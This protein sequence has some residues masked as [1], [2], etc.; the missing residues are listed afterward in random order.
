MT[1]SLK[2]P[3]QSPGAKEA[4]GELRGLE[5]QL[6]KTG[7]AGE[8]FGAKLQHAGD[9]LRAAR[10]IA[11][12]FASTVAGA[13]QTLID[14][15]VANEQQRRALE[16]LGSAYTA[17][18]AATRGAVTA[19]QALKTQQ[20]L[21]Q[22]GLRVSDQALA[23][24]TRTAREFARRTGGDTTQALEQLTE[25]LRNGDAGGLRR[26]GISVT[27]TGNRVRDFHR[28]LDQMS[29]GMRGATPSAVSL[30]EQ[31]QLMGQ[32]W[33][34]FKNSVTSNIA[35]LL[36][37]KEVFRGLTDLMR[38]VRE[39]GL[40]DGF[41]GYVR[42]RTQ[43]PYQEISEQ[44]L[45]AMREPGRFARAERERQARAT[46]FTQ[47]QQ[48]FITRARAGGVSARQLR[49]LET[50][51][52]GRQYSDQ[53]RESIAN[54][55]GRV[56]GRSVDAVA[57]QEGLNFVRRQQA[58]LDPTVE[59]RRE[60]EQ[61]QAEERA[62][63]AAMMQRRLAGQA[64][65]M[66]PSDAA[67]VREMG[68]Q[69]GQLIRQ[70]Q[71]AQLAIAQI[72]MRA[73]EGALH[74]LGRNIREFEQRLVTAQNRV[75]RHRGETEDAFLQRRIAVVQR[76]LQVVEEN[77]RAKREAI[78]ETTAAIKAQIEAD[79]R[80]KATAAN[81]QE[82]TRR[83]RRG[84]GFQLI[85]GLGQRATTAGLVQDAEGA[86]GLRGFNPGGAAR[87]TERGALLGRV[88]SLTEQAANTQDESTAEQLQA[89]AAAIAEVVGRYD[90]LRRS[91]QA[92][93]DTGLQF[94]QAFSQ[95]TELVSTSAQ[96][97]A[98]VASEAF[99]TFKGALK[100]HI[101]AVIAGKE[102]IG[103]ALRAITIATL[104]NLAERAGYEAIWETGK[105]IGKVA[106]G[107]YAG[108]GT[109]FA[110]AA[111]FTGL[112]VAGGFVANSLANGAGATA[113]GAASRGYVSQP[114]SATP[115]NSNAGGNTAV[116][117]INFNG[118][119]IGADQPERLNRF[120]SDH[121]NQALASGAIRRVA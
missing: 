20:D 88:Q 31:V 40:F 6:K 39:E 22:S 16:Q 62:E 111:A 70:A 28:A 71:R 96:T 65:G 82:I 106:L 42:E 86:L 90:E 104:S 78:D 93:N 112:A 33:D 46:A 121:V 50:L 89:Q 69:V 59:A 63:S 87:D 47:A 8:S 91:Q 29:A 37:L 56:G 97:M 12:A 105:G 38:H 61:R 2:V 95:H 48:Q 81:D 66:A 32:E 1:D 51:M 109:H 45:A 5:G 15:A 73:G 18:T 10:E 113:T 25:A 77:E 53:Q 24:I 11:G 57:F 92:A 41:R 75:Y 115:A 76:E 14:G 49:E 55:F 83:Q 118:S 99:G 54:L 52:E 3:V 23:A 21:V 102:S 117:N 72:Q 13:T 34:K 68:Q 79:E 98:S 27:G 110:A 67:V 74:Y 9:K 60:V 108:A 26:F 30:N 119:V 107:D 19:Q 58:G 80:V 4:T 7:E 103:E 116:V 114:A 101:G 17:V 64:E 94:A 44:E 84:A 85:R 43:M 120:I 36:N 100:Q 35:E